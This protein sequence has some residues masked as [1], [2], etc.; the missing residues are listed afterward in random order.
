[1]LCSAFTY[2]VTRRRIVDDADLVFFFVSSDYRYIGT[3][4]P[5]I[6]ENDFG[7]TTT[8]TTTAHQWQLEIEEAQLFVPVPPGDCVACVSEK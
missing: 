2:L 1:M 8:S 3:Q 4:T 6:T 5:R 7:S